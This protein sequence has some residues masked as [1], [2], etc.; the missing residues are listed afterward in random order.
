MI[1]MLGTMGAF[2]QLTSG[3]QTITLT[4]SVNESLTVTPSAG[5][6][7]F[8]VVNP[9]TATNGPGT[10][11]AITTD[12][13]LN[14]SR[15]NVR[16]CAYFGA[17]ATAM[18]GP[19]DNIPSSAIE[20]RGGALLG[21]TFTPINGNCG[22]GVAGAARTLADYAVGPGTRRATQVENFEFNLNL[23]TLPNLNAD[24][25]TGTLN[26]QAQATP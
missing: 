5:S 6:Y 10:T 19:A 1:A 4:A 15:T 17:A 9:G 7:D 8:G 21:A 18:T 20:V 25:Y 24:T 26:V 11:V 2:A 14:N 22:F 13:R 12:Y 23:T 16:L 3:A